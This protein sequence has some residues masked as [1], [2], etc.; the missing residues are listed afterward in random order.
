MDQNMSGQL[1]IGDKK[2][3]VKNFK[4]NYTEQVE[5]TIGTERL[6]RIFGPEIARAFYRGEGQ[7]CR[8]GNNYV[9]K[10]SY[11]SSRER[12]Y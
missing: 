8:Y 2:I 10:C 4:L 9:W 5:P 3:P 1:H 6:T 12:R 7:L 11:G